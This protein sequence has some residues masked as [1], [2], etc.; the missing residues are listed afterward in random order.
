MVKPDYQPETRVALD[1]PLKGIAEAR[2]AAI[3]GKGRT[4]GKRAL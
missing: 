2:L 3:C 1:Y 4:F